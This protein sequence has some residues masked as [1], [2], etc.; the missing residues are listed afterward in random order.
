MDGELLP[1]DVVQ[2]KLLAAADSAIRELARG[3]KDVDA[4][5]IEKALDDVDVATIIDM[6]SQSVAATEPLLVGR[7]GDEVIP[8][9]YRAPV[10]EMLRDA[11]DFAPPR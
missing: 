3:E 8:T 4:S 1:D 5:L 10:G 7:L 2:A 11:I 9:I 6:A